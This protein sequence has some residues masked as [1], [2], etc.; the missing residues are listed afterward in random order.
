MAFLFFL[1]PG[2]EQAD[3]KSSHGLAGITVLK[4]VPVYPPLI[5]LI[6]KAGRSQFDSFSEY[7]S[8]LEKAR[9]PNV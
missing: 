2:R 5:P 3:K 1:D 8:S 7:P 9:T 4:P 6:S